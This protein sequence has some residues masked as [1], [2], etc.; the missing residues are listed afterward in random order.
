MR[1]LIRAVVLGVFAATLSVLTGCTGMVQEDL[2][3]THRKLMDL[4][5]YVAGINDQLSNLERIV[6]ALDDSHS[7]LPG[8]YSESEGGYSISFKDGTTVFIPYGE[9]G[10]DGRTLIPVGVRND[11]DGHYYW[12]VDGDWFLVDSTMVRVDATD[13]VDGIAPQVKVEDGFWWI[14]FDGGVSFTQLASCDVMDGIG[15]FSD[16]PDLSDP[17]KFV[18]VLWDGT[19]IEIPY[20]VPLKIAFEGPV[21]DTLVVSAGETLS[22]PYEVLMEG[23]ASEPVVVTSGT[24]GVYLSQIVAGDEPGR[25]EVIVQAPNPF[26]E[27]YILLSAWCEGYSAVKMISFEER[28]IPV[29]SI[30]VRLSA[31]D[32]A[33]VFA[34]ETNFEYEVLSITYP[35]SE[36]DDVREWLEVIPDYE[37][38]TIIFKPRENN[39]RS[40]RTATVTI[41]PIDNPEFVITTFD[42]RQA[43]ETAILF[44]VFDEHSAFSFDLDEMTLRAPADGGEADIWMTTRPEL[45]LSVEIP[46]GED[47]VT[48]SMTAEDGFWRLH[49]NVEAIE[50]ENERSTEARISVRIFGIPLVFD[51]IKIIQ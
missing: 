20:Y 51:T 5:N 37:S 42:V 41:A 29:E 19:R 49:I 3:A 23:E 26:C 7:I 40:I 28:Q 48:A 30:T 39:G 27:G 45:P 43:T 34:Y 1:K 38:G 2:D 46:D 10:T 17:S 35:E 25:G 21:M 15:V 33:R 8:S 36:S 11:E 22:I 9:D 44:D 12:T 14:S 32:T 6:D 31:V 47:W 13:G 4:Q 50:P 24:D 18:L 16:H